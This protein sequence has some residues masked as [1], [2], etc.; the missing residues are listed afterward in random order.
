MGKFILI[1]V[2]SSFLCLNADAQDTVSAKMEV[3]YLVSYVSDTVKNTV[4]T[5]TF[6][7]RFNEEQ[8]LFYEQNTYLTD[9]LKHYDIAKWSD[10]MSK[11]LTTP[12]S[13]IKGEA[14]YYVFTDLEQSTYVYQDDISG[15]TYRYS[16]SLP[17]FDWQ[18]LPEYKLIAQNKCQ[19]AV[20]TYMGRKYEAWF[21]VNLPIKASPWKFAGLP[22][23]IMEVYDNQHFYTFKMIDMYPC[24]GEIS[25]FSSKHFKTSKDKFLKELMLYLKDPIAYYENQ[26]LIKIHFGSSSNDLEAEM[27][28]TNRHLPMELLK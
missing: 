22:G 23:L 2:L 8:S 1:L 17:S 18:I 4:L 12:T 25:L 3:K 10:M 19:K 6:C 24:S 21:S 20:G 27:R 5:D 14:T 16:D 28:N 7:L 11:I 26:A 9:S 13:E 15:S